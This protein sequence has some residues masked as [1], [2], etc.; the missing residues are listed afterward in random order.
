MF[1][2]LDKIVIGWYLD[3]NNLSPV[4]KTGMT[5]ASFMQSEKSPNSNKNIKKLISILQETSFK[6]F[7]LI[8]CFRFCQISN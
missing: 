5:L 7:V 4:L 3:I 6:L 2:K 1:E 8:W